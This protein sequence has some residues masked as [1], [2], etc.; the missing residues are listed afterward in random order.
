[1][2]TVPSSA[3]PRP[4]DETPIVAA[5]HLA[6]FEFSDAGT[7]V[8]MVEW[9]PGAVQAPAAS[10]DSSADPADPPSAPASDDVPAAEPAPASA[11]GD[12]ADAA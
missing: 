6:R 9:Y 7:K 1:M 5:Q 2:T 11:P 10:V 4:A 12:E 3:S 8:L